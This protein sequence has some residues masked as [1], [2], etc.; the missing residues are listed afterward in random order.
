MST[1]EPPSSQPSAFQPSSYEPPLASGEPA[2]VSR[3]RTSAV[4][5]GVW[6]GVVVLI[7]LI[8]FVGQ[9]TSSV[10][11]AFF[12]LEGSIPLALALLIAGVAGAIVA[13]AVAGLRILQLR[14][15]IRHGRT[16]ISR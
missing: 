12:G 16:P 14:K 7:L 3:T 10:A 13:M 8:I 1:P 4:W 9:N 11:I 15:Q 2:R 5:L 6:A